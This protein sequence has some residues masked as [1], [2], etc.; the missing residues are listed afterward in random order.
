[1]IS[2]E[3]ARWDIERKGLLLAALPSSMLKPKE[4]KEKFIVRNSTAKKFL[5]MAFAD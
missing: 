5:F 3:T 1:M 2:A 4:E